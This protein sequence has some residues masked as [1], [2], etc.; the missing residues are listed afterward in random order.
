VAFTPRVWCSR[1]GGSCIQP[2]LA[3]RAS[4]MTA[5]PLKVHSPLSMATKID[6]RWATKKI[7]HHLAIKSAQL[8]LNRFQQVLGRV[9]HRQIRGLEIPRLNHR[10]QC[11]AQLHVLGAESLTV[12]SQ[13]ANQ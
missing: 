6:R 1:T 13:I 11:W 3:R 9:A 2:R 7:V 4:S 12:T 10:K 8:G 5:K